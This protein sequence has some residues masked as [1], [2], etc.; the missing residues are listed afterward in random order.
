MEH[1]IECQ[2]NSTKM[3][4]SLSPFRILE[5]IEKIEIKI[6]SKKWVV[7]KLNTALRMSEEK[8][9]FPFNTVNIDSFK[10]YGHFTFGEDIRRF[11]FDENYEKYC[12]V[13]HF[14]GT[15]IQYDMTD[16]KYQ[17]CSSK[18]YDFVKK[19]NIEMERLNMRVILFYKPKPVEPEEPV[20][21]IIEEKKES[22]PVQEEHY[23]PRCTC[24]LVPH[25]MKEEGRKSLLKNYEEVMSKEFPDEDAQHLIHRYL[26]RKETFE[27]YRGFIEHG[28]L[29]VKR[30]IRFRRQ[31]SNYLIHESESLYLT[32]EAD[33]EHNAHFWDEGFIRRAFNKDEADQ[34]QVIGEAYGV[35]D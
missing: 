11:M 6:D 25:G 13:P 8:N 9:T 23:K 17:Q 16:E 27:K 7:L 5:L 28:M 4:F 35:F 12:T 24:W 20:E 15:F 18:L 26:R 22:P 33:R 34:L 2:L 3:T 31:L 10:Q 21:E 19:E 14:I 1:R 30:Q 29:Y 32:E